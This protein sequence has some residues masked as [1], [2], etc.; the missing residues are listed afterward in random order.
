MNRRL[1]LLL[2]SVVA[3]FSHLAFAQSPTAGQ[4]SA[5][6]FEKFTLDNGLTLIVHEDHKAP[7]VAVNV[8][9]HVGSKNE[10]PGKSGFAH[11]FEH[12]MF[13]GSENFNKDYFKALG[14]MGG[15]DLNGTTN[16]DR[17]NYFQNVPTSGLDRLLFLESDRMGHLLGAIDQA[18]LDEQRGV[19]QNEKRQGENQPYGLV[20]NEAVKVLFPSN[21][22]YAFPQGTVIG[23]ME[24]LNAASLKDVQEWFK[25]YYGPNNA[26]LVLAGDID[27]KTALEKVKKYFGDIP[28]GP[29][30]ARVN[31]WVPRLQQNVRKVMEDRV[32]QARWYRFWN[33]PAAGS[34]E[35]D[36]LDMY[37]DILG[38]GKTS[39]LFK[40]LVYTDQL[41]TDVGSFTDEGEISSTFELFVTAKPGADMAKIEKVVE[42]EMARLLKDGPTADELNRT[43][44]RFR[45]AHIRGLER[46][47]GFGGKSDVLASSWVYLGKPDGYLNSLRYYQNATVKNL[48]AAA[49]QWLQDGH[50]T[51]TVLPF[52]K[53]TATAATVDR[54]QMPA[55]ST[56]PTL[57]FPAIQRATLSNGLTVLLT[58]RKGLPLVNMT[59]RFKSSGFSS[60]TPATAGLASFAMDLLD[61]GTQKKDT[62]QLSEALANLGANLSTGAELDAATVNLNALSDQLDAS[63]ALMGEVI[64]TPRFAPADLDRLKQRRLAAISQEKT[65][66]QAT[67]LRIMPR[68][69]YGETHPYGMPL[70]GSGNEATVAKIGLAD[71]QGWAKAHLKPGSAVLTV[72][73]DITMATLTGKLERLFGPWPKGE[74]SAVNPANVTLADKP[75][76]YLL[77]R[78]GSQQ[79]IIMVGHSITPTNNADEIA[80]GSFNKAFGGDF[81]SRINMN[82]RE[83]KHWSYG[84]RTVV[85]DAV[86]PRPFVISAPVQTDKTKESMVE[87][88]KEITDIVTTKGINAEEFERVQADRVLQLPGR[89]ETSSAV[90]G[91]LGYLATYGLADDYY[92]TFADKIRGLKI[93]DLDA[94]A[95][96]TLKP[97][98]L[99]WVVVGDRA[100]VEGGVKS[101]NLGELKI[102]DANGTVV[103]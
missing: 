73:G 31:A 81:N 7:I 103:K 47:G 102:I 94:A 86:G 79:S 3:V 15:T 17:T 84:V 58:E 88:K 85:I 22:P 4:P 80:F 25:T 97:Q 51:L 96:K 29:P 21:H 70:T 27:A 32:P 61:E 69:M 20:E 37:S 49:K 87:L 67:A 28:A 9:Y 66:P 71:V 2:S 57:T 6:A 48:T 72:V 19:V 92:Q 78:P 5:I 18:K 14:A 8:W 38:R 11:L 90:Q 13:N 10:V 95:R 26:T 34:D 98:S 53:F 100:K 52:S 65:S 74:A 46:I 12:L 1:P 56:P 24:D 89:W 50:L 39:R 30:V 68:L 45:A 16:R 93:A 60:D 99:I 41:A 23:S 62:L 63:L 101:L 43:K 33:V 83:D 36:A 82:L 64:L 91:A 55:M 35:L 59:L 42:E 77:D 44:T 76:V 40:R 54:K 75:T